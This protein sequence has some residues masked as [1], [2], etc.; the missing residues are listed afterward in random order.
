MSKQ[1]VVLHTSLSSDP[2]NVRIHGRDTVTSFDCDFHEAIITPVR[3]PRILDKPVRFRSS[4]RK[5]WILGATV[6]LGLI[7]EL[8]ATGF[9]F[10]F[11]FILVNVTL[12]VHLRVTFKIHSD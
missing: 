8:S 1:V 5:V 9:L 7:V 6:I 12:P 10:K 4:F 11:F 3:A 2:L